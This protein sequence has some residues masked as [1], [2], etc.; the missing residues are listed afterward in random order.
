MALA[1]IDRKGY[2]YRMSNQRETQGAALRAWRD[3]Q[4]PRL[5]Q[6]G[7]AERLRDFNTDRRK[8]TQAAWVAW[9]KGWK[10]PDLFF[11][12]AL[13]RMTNGRVSAQGW[14]MPRQMPE[15]DKAT[16]APD[17]PPEPHRRAS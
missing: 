10:A 14:A 16:P 15:H 1:F 3:E 7:A 2:Q 6:R 13:E 17:S 5:S 12:F 11:A 9:E 4:V 8:A